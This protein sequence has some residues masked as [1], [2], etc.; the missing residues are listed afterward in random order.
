MTIVCATNEGLYAACKAGPAGRVIFESLS[1]TGVLS[2]YSGLY[3]VIYCL[4][5]REGG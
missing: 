1:S 3:Y 5:R 2:V 4:K